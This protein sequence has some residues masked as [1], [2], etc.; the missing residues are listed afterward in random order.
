MP[1]DKINEIRQPHWVCSGEDAQRELGWIPKVKLREGT[2][3]TARWYREN[4]WL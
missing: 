4:G 1:Q 3:L 2:E